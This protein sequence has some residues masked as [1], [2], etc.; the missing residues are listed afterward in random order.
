MYIASHTHIDAI[1]VVHACCHDQYNKYLNRPHCMV[2]HTW[3]MKSHHIHANVCE[4]VSVFGWPG[5]LHFN[6]QSGVVHPSAVWLAHHAGKSI[7]HPGVTALGAIHMCTCVCCARNAR[8]D[9]LGG[10]M[11]GVHPQPNT[12]TTCD[13]VEMWLSPGLRNR[14]IRFVRYIDMKCDT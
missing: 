13:R 9:R 1:M 12:G 5:S 14:E 11:C 3:T 4:C 10:D 7:T 6:E 2:T 8:T